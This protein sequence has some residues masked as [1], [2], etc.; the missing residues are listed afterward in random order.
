MW[1]CWQRRTQRKVGVLLEQE[2]QET[3]QPHP[4]EWDAPE[5]NPHCVAVVLPEKSTQGARD[6]ERTRRGRCVPSVVVL[7]EKKPH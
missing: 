5:K 3:Q 1:G 4:G 2:N 6:T 7:S